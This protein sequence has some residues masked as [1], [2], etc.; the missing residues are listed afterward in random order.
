MFKMKELYQTVERDSSLQAKF[1]Q[2]MAEAE[3]DGQRVTEDKL[4]AFAREAGFEVS[5]EEMQLFFEGM[6]TQ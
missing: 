1:N 3:G 4:L 2:V 5:L 6:A